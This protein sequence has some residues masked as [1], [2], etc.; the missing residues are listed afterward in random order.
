MTD[1][2]PLFG[3]KICHLQSNPSAARRALRNPVPRAPAT[4]RRAAGK[5]DIFVNI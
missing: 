4:P 3:A 2:G 1:F 5:I